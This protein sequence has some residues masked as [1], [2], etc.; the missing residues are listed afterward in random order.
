[1]LE[2]HGWV[3]IIE[4]YEWENEGDNEHKIVDE[5]EQFVN[6]IDPDKN[7]CNARW[8]NG[9]FSITV[10]LFSKRFRQNAQDVF[11]LFNFIGKIATGSYGLLYLCAT[12]AISDFKHM[13][14]G[15]E[16]KVFV[17]ARGVLTER[18]DE[19]LS[20]LIPTVEDPMPEGYYDDEDDD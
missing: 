13:L 6:N 15:Y 2:L 8:M 7:F 17:L 12:D 16:F 14:T 10:R 3:T 19:F 5:I 1:M 9:Y 11:D 20:P 18:K 4:S